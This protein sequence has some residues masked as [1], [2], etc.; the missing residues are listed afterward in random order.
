MRQHTA[1]SPLIRVT[2]A[3]GT[4]AARCAGYGQGPFSIVIFV[5]ELTCHGN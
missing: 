5:K 2:V 4:L 3:F 1:S